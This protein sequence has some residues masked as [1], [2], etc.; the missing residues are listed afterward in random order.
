MRKDIEVKAGEEDYFN[1]NMA[2]KHNFKSSISNIS[3]IPASLLSS[4]V[5]DDSWG[6]FTKESLL[7]SNKDE[8]F[9]YQKL[10]GKYRYLWRTTV[11]DIVKKIQD[12]GHVFRYVSLYYRPR[13]S[14]TYF[15]FEI[16][17]YN[18]CLRPMGY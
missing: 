1:V 2:G 16:N 10:G 11:T 15:L 4:I 12:D 18:F 17:F 13:G 14:F 7:F 6:F 3:R 9:G 5:D 8:V